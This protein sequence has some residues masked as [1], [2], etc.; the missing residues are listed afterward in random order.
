M[1]IRSK[2]RISFISICF[3]FYSNSAACVSSEIFSYFCYCFQTKNRYGIAI[4][5]TMIARLK[6]MFREVFLCINILEDI[7]VSKN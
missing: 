3:V 4:L 1:T 5:N 2:D 6:M 7:E